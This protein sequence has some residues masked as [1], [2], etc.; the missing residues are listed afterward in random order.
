M[1]KERNANWIFKYDYSGDKVNIWSAF[2]CSYCTAMYQFPKNK[3]FRY[4][5]NCGS[6]MILDEEKCK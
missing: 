5:P 3:K 1:D 4:C 2:K 6:K